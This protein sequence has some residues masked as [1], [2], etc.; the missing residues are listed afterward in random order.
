[1]EF[2]LNPA[3]DPDELGA[4]Y[5]RRKRLHVPDLLEPNS[6][7]ALYQHLA[8]ELEWHLTFR[9]EEKSHEITSENQ[10]SAPPERDIIAYSY[11]RAQQGA[12]QYLYDHYRTSRVIDQP[13]GSPTLLIR[14]VN[15]LNSPD[16][17]AFMRKLTGH[18][19]I[20][21]ANALATRYRPGHFLTQHDDQDGEDLKRRAAY[22]FNLTPGWR[23]DWGGQLQFI[24]D[25][26][27]VEQA[28]VPRFNALNVFSV[29]QH[30]AVS[31]VTPF[32]GGP[33]LSITG[34]FR[35]E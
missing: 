12:F 2:S 22:V 21:K 1:M 25:D 26:G 15:F 29:P 24:G 23:P 30:H 7:R 18:E 16:F 3:L 5:S 28:Y 6:A 20:A 35:T 8:R 13:D 11:K 27:H 33:R 14:F 10:A 31:L 9:S 34:W 17:L 4:A 32:A 19:D